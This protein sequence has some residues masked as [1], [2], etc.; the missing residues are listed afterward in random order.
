MCSLFWIILD[1]VCYT[2]HNTPLGSGALAWE[3]AVHNFIGAL[4]DISSRY[5]A[6]EGSMVA[7]S[8]ASFLRSF[9][10][11]ELQLRC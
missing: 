10:D 6:F 9:V 5:W 2:I 7:S 1:A 8:A 11:H 3:I 4:G